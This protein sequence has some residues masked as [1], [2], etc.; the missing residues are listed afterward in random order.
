[1]EEPQ[2][3]ALSQVAKRLLARESLFARHLE[4]SSS[5]VIV[6]VGMQIVWVNAAAVRCFGGTD[7][8][9]AEG[10]CL[11][12]LF[13]PDDATRFAAL[14]PSLLADD[15][16]AARAIFEMRRFDGPG[17][18]HMGLSALAIEFEGQT[19][20]VTTCDVACKCV[21]GLEDV[22][23]RR[24]DDDAEA[25]GTTP[26]EVA[27][28]AEVLLVVEDDPRVRGIL[29]RVL[30]RAGYRVCQASDANEARTVASSMPHIDLLITD[31]VMP[32][33]DG[34]VLASEFVRQR[35]GVAVLFISGYLRDVRALESL[36]A[37]LQKPFS[38][39]SLLRAVREVIDAARRPD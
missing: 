7:R 8:G 26:S 27:P 6:H 35:P 28:G 18:L 1:M 5:P 12:A 32:G 14:L 39:T 24:R 36:G 11:D 17:R 13:D 37:F 34:G 29:V 19:F 10:R 3:P 31:V 30:S 15:V 9:D 33:D 22:T 16:G 38:P 25:S 4:R 2:K 21:P 23:A 20:V